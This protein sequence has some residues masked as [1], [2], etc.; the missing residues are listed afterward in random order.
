MK[1]PIARTVFAVAMLAVCAY[2]FMS[3]SGPNGL[4]ALSEKKQQ[5][6]QAEKHNAELAR[7]IERTREHIKRLEQSPAEQELEIRDR[8]K[9]V[10]PT[11]KVYVIGDPAQTP[12]KR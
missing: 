3:L 2:A 6:R 5:I 4:H 12:P 7:E 9:L 10:H 8:L 1:T 11:D